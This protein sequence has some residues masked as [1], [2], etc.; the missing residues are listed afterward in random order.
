VIATTKQVR[1]LWLIKGLGLG[2]AERLLV[3]ALPYLNRDEFEYE[4]GYFLP[5][6][7]ALVPQLEA[8]GLHQAANAKQIRK[9]RIRMFQNV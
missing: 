4:V 6:K 8:A 5:W 9:P 7:D 1:V 3:A 2:G